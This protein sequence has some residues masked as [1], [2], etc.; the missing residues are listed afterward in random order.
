MLVWTSGG[1]TVDIDDLAVDVV[2]RRYGAIL[3]I[4]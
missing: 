3:F 1:I 4:N 2:E